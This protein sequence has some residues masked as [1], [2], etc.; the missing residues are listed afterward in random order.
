M[1][2]YRDDIE[3]DLSVF[4]RVD[5]VDRL[6]ITRLLALAPRLS[7]YAGALR[8]RYAEGASNAPAAPADVRGVPLAA[9]GAG[10]TP[11]EVVAALK[12]QAMAARFGV[13]PGAIETV[14]TDV[15][16]SELRA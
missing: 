11:P 2:E 5:D 12:R 1:A 3:S 9:D 4:H 7:A 14:S 10:D 13:D 16:L 15:L 8:A 6:T